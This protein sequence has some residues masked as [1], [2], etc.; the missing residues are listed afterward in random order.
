MVAVGA[1]G[2]TRITMSFLLSLLGDGNY[3]G[4]EAPVSSKHHWSY[5]GPEGPDS[6]HVH[7]KHCGGERQSPID[8]RPMECEYDPTLGPFVLDHFDMTSARAGPCV[9]NVTNNGHAASVRISND[10]M[11]VRGGGLAGT[12]KTAEFHFHW[13]STDDH[14]SE[15]AVD[16]RK[17]PLE[18]HVVNFAEK[19]GTIQQAMNKPDGLAVLGVFFQLSEQDNPNFAALDSALRHVHKAGE[20]AL[21]E[22]FTLRSLLPDDVS[23]YWRYSGSLTTPYCFESVTWTVF[24]EPQKI[25]RAQIETLRSLLHEEGHEMNDR[26]DNHHAPSRLLDNW[27]PVQPL[28]TRV[29]R[30]SFPDPT[31][32]GAYVVQPAVPA[33]ASPAPATTAQSTASPTAAPNAN[34]NSIKHANDN[35]INHANDNS[36]N[37]APPRP[38]QYQNPDMIDSQLANQLYSP[39]SPTTNFD[40]SNTLSNPAKPEPNHDPHNGKLLMSATAHDKPGSSVRSASTTQPEVATTRLTTSDGSPNSNSSGGFLENI[41]RDLEG[42]PGAINNIHQLFDNKREPH[43]INSI[44]FLTSGASEVWGSNPAQQSVHDGKSG[45]GDTR[46]HAVSMATSTVNPAGGQ[47]GVAPQSNLTA[48]VGQS[49]PTANVGQSNLT[50]N[51]GQSNL[52]AN[53]GQARTEQVVMVTSLPT[54]SPATSVPHVSLATLGPQAPAPP[55][56]HRLTA[57][58]TGSVP[59]A[60]PRDPPRTTAESLSHH[61]LLLRLQELE[62]QKQEL[63]QLHQKQLSDLNTHQL[64]NQQLQ[65]LQ[66]NPAQSPLYQPQTEYPYQ[67][68]QLQQQQ[69]QYNRER[70][71]QQFDYKGPQPL[72]NQLMDR[73]DEH[74]QAN[75]KL[76]YNARVPQ[77]APN[78]R[79]N[80]PSLDLNYRSPRTDIPPP[81]VQRTHNQHL[82]SDQ[83][84]SILEKLALTSRINAGMAYP[85]TRAAYGG[86][87]PHPNGFRDGDFLVLH[88]ATGNTYLVKAGSQDPAGLRSQDPAGLRSQDPASLRHLGEP[89]VVVQGPLAR[90][91]QISPAAAISMKQAGN[92]LRDDPQGVFLNMVDRPVRISSP[93]F[94]QL[95]NWR[96]QRLLQ[97]LEPSGVPAQGP[98]Q[99]PAVRQQLRTYPTQTNRLG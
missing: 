39:G 68:Q 24:T 30:R 37:H 58:P 5:K 78:T 12:Y 72:F 29:V 81:P 16:A 87:L 74:Y 92:G 20:Y 13:G 85:Q 33:T 95:Q 55:G 90:Q 1:D 91:F 2:M 3:P 34:D 84:R 52:T 67:Q 47:P 42:P 65:H 19:Y 96:Q 45:A 99:G 93:F 40:G 36:I 51:V 54:G 66:Y 97:Q 10:D 61:Q 27:R 38:T 46:E 59:P 32:G 71:L 4:P 50:A 94:D 77:Y 98:A 89:P 76:R 86:Q 79:A 8:I 23:K 70:Q 21:L 28:G 22:Q 17:F 35:S 25:A 9:L 57:P 73:T 88:R 48:N 63:L 64:T 41:L 44:E 83:I 14:G 56:S 69:Q 60:P 26:G 43:A 18:M 31:A 11:R 62:R 82:T 80:N 49:N 6:W 15:H 53:V 75:T 7:Y